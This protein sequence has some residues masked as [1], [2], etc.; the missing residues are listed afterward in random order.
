MKYRISRQKMLENLLQK[1]IKEL[2]IFL[3]I[4]S[5]KIMMKLKLLFQNI[6]TLEEVNMVQNLML[7]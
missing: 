3:I 2:K 7:K 6:Y 5:G 1:E 4:N